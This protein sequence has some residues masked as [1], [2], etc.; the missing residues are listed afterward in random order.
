MPYDKSSSQE[1]MGKV[2]KYWDKFLP[3]YLQSDKFYEK[4]YK[5]IRIA[6][7]LCIFRITED[8]TIYGLKDMINLYIKEK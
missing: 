5:I 8:K 3:K 7:C 6:S 4:L 2:K 1:E